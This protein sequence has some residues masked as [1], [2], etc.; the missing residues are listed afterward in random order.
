M[1]QAMINSQGNILDRALSSIPSGMSAEAARYFL[2]IT[3]ADSDRRR[4]GELAAK[5][6]DGSLSEQEQTELDEYRR[7][8]RTIEMLR[9][10]ARSVVDAIK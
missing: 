2:S 3:L 6:R 8:G 9:I 4:A 1:P 10:R 7:A 5:A